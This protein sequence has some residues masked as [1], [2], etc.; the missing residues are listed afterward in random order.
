MLLFKDVHCPS[1]STEYA[2]T[3]SS[4]KVVHY[5]LISCRIKRLHLDSARRE[6]TVWEFGPKVSEN[7]PP[8]ARA[9]TA[10]SNN[11]IQQRP[12][13]CNCFTFRYVLGRGSNL[14]LRA[15]R[16][17][18]WAMGPG[19][20]QARERRDVSLFQLFDFSCLTNSSFFRFW[21]DVPESASELI[22]Q[23]RRWLNGTIWSPT[24]GEY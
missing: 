17:S 18:E 4:N 14:V 16:E 13:W 3:Q 22:S 7:F 5:W 9:N 12:D 2:P 21:R 8:L 11:R 19:I 1:T 10:R 15:G 23:R 6:R 20:R 24:V